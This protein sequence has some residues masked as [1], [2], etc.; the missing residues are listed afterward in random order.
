MRRALVALA[1]TSCGPATSPAT[2]WVRTVNAV[3]SPHTLRITTCFDGPAPARVRL[4][5]DTAAIV[6]VTRGARLPSADGLVTL[7]PATR[8]VRQEFAASGDAREAGGFVLSHRAWLW[9]PEPMTAGLRQEARYELPPGWSVSTP[10]DGPAAIDPTAMQWGGYTVVGP[11]ARE[12]FTLG[13]IV[14]DVARLG[15]TSRPE[16][17]VRAWL[18]RAV[19]AIRT[20]DPALPI[21]R[22]QVILTP[23]PG[24]PEGVS[25]GLVSRGGGRSVLLLVDPMAAPEAFRDDWQATHE[26]TH[27]LQPV[28]VDDDAWLSEGMATYYQEVLRARVGAITRETCWAH[29]A[30]S[31]RAGHAMGG[32]RTLAEASAS[33]RRT[34]RYAR[35]Y[36]WGAAFALTLDVALRRAGSSLDAAARGL[37]AAAARDPGRAW[38]ATEALAAMDA[39]LGTTACSELGR[40]AL[41]AR[42]YPD[43][44]AALRELGVRVEADGAV[45]FDDAAP[46]AAVREAIT[47]GGLTGG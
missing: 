9:G 13:G 32:D 19:E 42:A 25:F 23:S 10:W 7:A 30:N 26:F 29:L 5:D 18:G 47:R 40:A 45:R 31:M 24:N 36:W 46:L 2:R 27:L 28:L 22:V 20:L 35:V 34:H 39:S 38:R 33:M 1:L 8:C 3:E 14:L 43:V 16:L 11:F 6:D 41:A 12:T 37:H 44:E 15:G 21:P 4:R 17:P